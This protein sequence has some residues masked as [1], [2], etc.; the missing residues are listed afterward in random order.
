MYCCCKLP[1]LKCGV[2]LLLATGHA[3]WGRPA[4]FDAGS[5]TSGH[6]GELPQLLGALGQGVWNKAL[7]SYLERAR[8]TGQAS[9]NTSKLAPL[10]APVQALSNVPPALPR[11]ISV[12][13]NSNQHARVSSP[14]GVA[15]PGGGTG[16]PGVRTAT[17]APSGD[18]LSRAGST[19]W[20]ELAQE[21]AEVE[22]MQ[23]TVITGTRDRGT[24]PAGGIQG[25]FLGRPD[26][27][28]D[29]S[30]A[31][32]GATAGILRLAG[33]QGRLPA[34]V[35]QSPSPPPPPP[36]V[37]MGILTNAVLRA[38]NT[39]GVLGVTRM[40]D[41]LQ[42]YNRYGPPLGFLPFCQ[43]F[44]AYGRCKNWVRR[45]LLYTFFGGN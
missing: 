11:N 26:L 5:G 40:M 16:A 12:R 39:S 1:S 23:D 17:P 41:P 42:L 3:T 29:T 32:E 24:A 6:Q 28:Q 9:N 25:S 21:A 13:S 14:D 37:P 30:Y 4:L 35:I 22:D 18:R 27:V 44:P 8:P 20:A 15:S 31:L 43:P 19:N 34:A 7:F 38:I 33:W 10:P 45:G 36:P 2:L